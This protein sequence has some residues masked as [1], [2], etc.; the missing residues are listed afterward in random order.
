VSTSLKIDEQDGAQVVKFETRAQETNQAIYEWSTSE[1]LTVYDVPSNPTGFPYSIDPPTA[2]VLTS[3]SA[4]ALTG[5]D[6]VITPRIKAVWVP[7]TDVRVTQI[8]VQYQKVGDTT[9]L[10]SAPVDFTTTS[11]FISGVVAGQSYNVQI[12]SLTNSGATSVWVSATQLVSAPNTLQST[13]TNNPKF[14]LTQPTSTTIAVASVAVTFGTRIVTYAARTLTITVPSVPTW[15]YVTIADS[16]QVGESGSPTLTATP[17][18]TTSLVGVSGNTYLGAILALPAGSATSIL[19]GGWPAPQ[20]V[21][22]GS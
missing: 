8:Q 13:Y 22:V 9:W 21:Q 15:Y 1:E 18:T 6:G 4:T 7:P 12:R 5:A 16:T 17:S 11:T 14:S 3:S 2:L 10:D 20:S 19:A